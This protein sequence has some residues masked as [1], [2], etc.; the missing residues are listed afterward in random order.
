MGED[1]R[2]ATAARGEAAISRLVEQLAGQ[3]EA[4]LS[5]G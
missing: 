2:T 5:P 3:I 4:H 1:A